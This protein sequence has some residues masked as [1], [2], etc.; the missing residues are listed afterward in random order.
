MVLEKKYDLRFVADMIGYQLDVTLTKK[1][2][3]ILFD[4]LNI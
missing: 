2:F 1:S 3:R 4:F